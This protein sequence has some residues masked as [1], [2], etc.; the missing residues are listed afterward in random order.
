[1]VQGAAQLAL[2]LSFA[3]FD[4][5]STVWE[6]NGAQIASNFPKSSQM[7]PRSPLSPP[8]QLPHIRPPPAQPSPNAICQH[9]AREARIN[10]ITPTGA[11]ARAHLSCPTDLS[12]RANEQTSER[13]PNALSTSPITLVVV[14]HGWWHTHKKNPHQYFSTVS[15]LT[16]DL[17]SCKQCCP[18]FWNCLQV[19]KGA[20]L[21]GHAHITTSQPETALK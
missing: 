1:M 12:E 21:N 11:P 19:E 14:S 15:P 5:H 18:A 9:R 10:L 3:I 2:I 16:P 4:G 20:S 17:C 13:E 7:Y 8:P 6:R